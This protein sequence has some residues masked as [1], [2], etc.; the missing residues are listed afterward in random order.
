[1]NHIFFQFTFKTIVIYFFFCLLTD[2]DQRDI[3]S[4]KELIY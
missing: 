2:I 1:M 3:N 4:V